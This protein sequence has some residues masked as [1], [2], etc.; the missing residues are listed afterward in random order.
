MSVCTFAYIPTERQ[1]DREKERGRAICPLHVP[2]QSLE[3]FSRHSLTALGFFRLA[4]ISVLTLRNNYHDING[5]LIL[6]TSN[7]TLIARKKNLKITCV[8]SQVSN[9]E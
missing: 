8:S 4:F 5:N 9:I 7:T 2:D 6:E 3:V 1:K